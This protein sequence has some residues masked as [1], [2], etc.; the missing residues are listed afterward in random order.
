MQIDEIIK[1]RT[2]VQTEN[3]IKTIP[4]NWNVEA[5]NILKI[6]MQ[7][8]PIKTNQNNEYIVGTGFQID[9]KNK[10]LLRNLLIYFSGNEKGAYSLN[11]GLLLI[12]GVGTGKTILMKIFKEYTMNILQSNSF[13]NYSAQDI[14]HNVETDGLKILK[15]FGTTIQKP[16]VCYFD[17]IASA[18]EIVNYYGTKTN[19]IETLL[20]MRYE[21]FSRFGKLTHLTTNKTPL[22][23]RKVYGER[24]FDR[25]KE[26]F[27]IVLLDSGS[28]RK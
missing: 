23:L 27:N 28:R 12:G 24:V 13:V 11:K 5:N 19:V 3:I 2:G 20:S 22:E 9:E 14:V 16:S 4:I 18:N 21:V 1:N 7:F 8:I 6:G 17:D 15:E 26:M 10:G 25:M